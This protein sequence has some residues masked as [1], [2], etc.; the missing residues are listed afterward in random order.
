MHTVDS[1]VLKRDE[2]GEWLLSAV[3]KKLI[4]QGLINIE[5]G[6]MWKSGDNTFDGVIK[7]P[8]HSEDGKTYEIIHVSG[9]KDKDSDKRRSDQHLDN[10]I[11]RFA[12]GE[13]NIKDIN[14]VK[15]FYPEAIIK[16]PVNLYRMI[17]P[18]VKDLRKNKIN[19]KQ[20][21]VQYISS[22]GGD[23]YASW[24]TKKQGIDYFIKVST[25]SRAS[26]P[27]NKKGIV[28]LPVFIILSQKNTGVDLTKLVKI[29][30]KTKDYIES[31]VPVSR[32]YA[33]KGAHE[34]L[35][36]SK[37]PKILTVQVPYF[38]KGKKKAV[39]HIDPNEI[40]IVYEIR[41]QL[42]QQGYWKSAH[43]TTG[44]FDTSY[45]PESFKQFLIRENSDKDLLDCL[46][47]LTS[48]TEK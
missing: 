32:A 31:S 16:K 33:L 23:K 8:K 41:K 43:T 14:Y 40:E 19:T 9:E 37:S 13:Q 1:S 22:V 42:Q 11:E 34:V 27:D 36:T 3:G 6:L 28:E 47:S 12:E 17:V 44:D 7:D 21:L 20:Q 24:S 39:A 18:S 46:E 45:I 15:K 26:F 25:N 29:I 2:F 4:K 35:A 30:D 48:W 5:D 10:I 38:K